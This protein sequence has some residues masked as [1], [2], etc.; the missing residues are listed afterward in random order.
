MVYAAIFH[1]CSVFQ[2]PR[3]LHREKQICCYLIIGVFGKYVNEKFYYVFG[4][5]NK[6]ICKKTFNGIKF[7]LSKGGF[8]VEKLVPAI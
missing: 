4:F 7:V 2:L 3:L 1:P 8:I 6:V 5:P